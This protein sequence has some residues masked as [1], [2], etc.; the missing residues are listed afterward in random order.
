MNEQFG[1][2]SIGHDIDA[3]LIVSHAT[4][5]VVADAYGSASAFSQNRLKHD[6]TAE[7]LRFARRKGVR[8]RCYRLVECNVVRQVAFLRTV[9]PTV[10]Y[11]H[12]CDGANSLFPHKH[13]VVTVD[14]ETEPETITARLPDET[15]VGS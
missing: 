15:P 9:L 8:R 5:D 10:G 13:D 14:G 2:L 4:C 11:V 3:V 12:G 1:N 6:D 7:T